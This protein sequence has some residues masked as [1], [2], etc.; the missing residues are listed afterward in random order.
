MLE[1]ETQERRTDSMRVFEEIK[2][3]EGFDLEPRPG[4]PLVGRRL[5]VLTSVDDGVLYKANNT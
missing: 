3:D 1:K 5:N 2:K 4:M